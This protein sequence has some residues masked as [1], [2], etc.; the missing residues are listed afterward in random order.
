[1][2]SGKYGALKAFTKIIKSDN[3]PG[4]DL[5]GIHFPSLATAFGCKSIRVGRAQDVADALAQALGEPGPMLV[6]IAVDP[7][8]GAV[9]L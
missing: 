1:M 3:V 6:E 4:M 2:D 5:P 9:Y 8:A 7:N